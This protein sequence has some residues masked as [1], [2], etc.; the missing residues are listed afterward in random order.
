MNSQFIREET[1]NGEQMKK[2]WDLFNQRYKI[3]TMVNYDTIPIQLD[4]N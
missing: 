4:K 2:S 1:Q 3:K